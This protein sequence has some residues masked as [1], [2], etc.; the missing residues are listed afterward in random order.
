M[1]TRLWS[2]GS[3]PSTRS[4][5]LRILWQD[6]RRRNRDDELTGVFSLFHH[7]LLLVIPGEHQRERGLLLSEPLRLDDGYV[8][9]WREPSDLLGSCIDQVGQLLSPYPGEVEEGVSLGGSVVT[10]DLSSP[11]PCVLADVV[12]LWSDAIW[13]RSSLSTSPLARPLRS[14]LRCASFEPPNVARVSTPCALPMCA[15]F[16]AGSTPRIFTPISFNASKNVPSLL[17]IP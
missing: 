13:A 10:P 15:I 12:S 9:P 8:S 3:G 2:S 14:R 5:T 7:N 6:P 1:E 17:P 16:L 11:R 4:N